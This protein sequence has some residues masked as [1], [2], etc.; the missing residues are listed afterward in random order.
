M[1]A[2]FLSR[3]GA[4][5]ALLAA[6]ILLPFA[7]MQGTFNGLSLIVL[8]LVIAGVWRIAVEERMFT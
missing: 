2:Q 4:A 8:G 7:I 1:V 6:V 5:L 3:H